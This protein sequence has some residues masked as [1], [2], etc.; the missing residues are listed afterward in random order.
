MERDADTL[1]KVNQAILSRLDRI[2]SILDRVCHYLAVE[3]GLDIGYFSSGS[4]MMLND[5]AKELLEKSG[6]KDFADSQADALI[7]EIEKKAPTNKLDV[8]Q[9]SIMT[10]FDATNMPQF[11]KV[12]NFIYENPVYNGGKVDLSTLVDIVAVYIRDKYLEKH[13]EL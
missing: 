10:V 8:Q 12:K 9:T 6:A 3:G 4:P 13:P 1:S 5:L 11:D 7:A 2:E